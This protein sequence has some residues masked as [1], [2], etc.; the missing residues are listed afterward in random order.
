MKQSTAI[1]KIFLTFAGVIVFLHFLLHPVRIWG[2]QTSLFYLD[3]KFTFG[4]YYTVVTYFLASFFGLLATLRMK[5]GREK[6]LS[7]GLSAFFFLLSFDEFFE[8]HEYIREV[9]D[10]AL[11][12]GSFAEMLTRISWIFPF[13]LVIV[14]VFSLLLYSVFT[15]HNKKIRNLFMIG[16]CLYAFV[17]VLEV[18]GGML[19]GY[20]IYITFVG[21]EEGMEMAS[22]AVFLY[23][24]MEKNL[25]AN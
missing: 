24:M 25:H 9:I 7:G 15:E 1:F 2:W 10:K 17:L 14:G 20:P 5:K 19:Y 11:T 8:V 18:F 16:I 23:A 3:E 22:G 13:L 21:L 6:I 12:T 4:T